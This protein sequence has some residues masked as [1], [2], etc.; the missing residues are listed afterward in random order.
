MSRRST[1]AS[2]NKNTQ[3]AT[4]AP[5][6]APVATASVETLGAAEAALELPTV[7][8]L[9]T[10]QRRYGNRAASLIQRQSSDGGELDSNIS[11]QI[12]RTRGG[13]SPL[14]IGLR[15][16]LEQSFG[17]NFSGVRVHTDQQADTLN[18]S[19]QAKAFTLGS[20]IYFRKGNYQ[21]GTSGGQELLAH[22]LTHVV[23]QGGARVSRVQTKLTVGPVGD[24]YE[25]EAD[26]VA[27]QVVSGLSRSHIQRAPL[28]RV[29][30]KAASTVQRKF[31]LNPLNWFKSDEQIKQ[32]QEKSEKKKAAKQGEIKASLEDGAAYERHLGKYIYNHATANTAAKTVN[33]KLVSALVPEF[34]AEDEAQQK[35]IGQT[36]G[37]TG[38]KYAG[39][40]GQEFADVWAVLQSGNLRERMTATYNAMFGGFKTVFL[41]LIKRSAWS[42]AE[43]RGFDARKLK[44]RKRQLSNPFKGGNWG[45]KKDTYGGA[46]DY[47]IYREPRN[48]LDRKNMGSM[49]SGLL[50]KKTRYEKPKGE[51]TITKRK[52]GELNEGRF[53]AGLSDREKK[54]MFSNKDRTADVSDERLSWEEGGSKWDMNDKSAWVQRIKND[55]KMPVIAGPSGTALRFFQMWEWLKKPIKSVEWRLALLG[56]MLVEND[57]SFHE[58]MQMGVDYGAPYKAGQEAYKSIDPLT[59]GELRHNV[60]VDPKYPGL[61]PD[62]IA[63]H[64]K[65]D[66][67]GFKLMAPYKEDMDERTSHA[68]LIKDQFGMKKGAYDKSGLPQLLKGVTAY[69]TIAYQI[70]NIVAGSS[71]LV[72]KARIAYMLSKN[73][74]RTTLLDLMAK[75]KIGIKLTDEENKQF[76]DEWDTMSFADR[77]ICLVLDY[78]P[79]VTASELI[80]ESKEHNKQTA[81][82]LKL[83]PKFQG[84]VYRG[85]SNIGMP[86]KKGKQIKLSKFLST[87]RQTGY[88]TS[89][90]KAGRFLTPI[91]LVIESKTGRDVNAVTVNEDEDVRKGRKAANLD[92]VVLLPGTTLS[93]ESEPETDAR[94]PGIQAV[95]LTE[96]GEGKDENVLQQEITGPLIEGTDDE[97]AK[98]TVTGRLYTTTGDFNGGWMPADFS[99]S[100]PAGSVLEV[101]DDR[102]PD[103]VGDPITDWIQCKLGA[104]TVYVLAYDLSTSAKPQTTGGDVTPVVDDSE[105]VK[106]ENRRKFGHLKTG[107]YPI[108][109][110]AGRKLIVF[111]DETATEATP[112]EFSAEQ[113]ARL[114]IYPLGVENG[115]CRLE[116]SGKTYYVSISDVFD[117]SGAVLPEGPKESPKV[118]DEPPVDD[119]DLDSDTPITDLFTGDQLSTMMASNDDLQ[120]II[121]M[122][123]IE[124]GQLK[125]LTDEQI[126]QL[127]AHIKLKVEDL[128][129]QILALS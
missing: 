5:Q 73:R 114:V 79:E 40:V 51:D 26:R 34:K 45:R 12:N 56:W 35:I 95:K 125:T 89:Y 19:V 116:F 3:T 57:H 107:K 36:F 61:F 43:K 72:A 7:N 64:R 9:L 62:E 31:S 126:V 127:A 80:E 25:Q 29:Q 23:Q 128:K 68:Q 118:E 21:P 37:G 86:Y 119:K 15:G 122:G 18:R 84:T 1:P 123:T 59:T 2:Q 82:G 55:L 42:E 121:D 88:V 113:P 16:P 111:K 49:E 109:F 75:Q 6:R 110:P 60:C 67:G 105:R 102:Y 66:A 103:K 120:F 63:Y 41:D 44:I 106:E 22:E 100:I 108:K 8:G 28:A 65:L 52:V 53:K 4:A 115:R 13:G 11:D 90:A 46:D 27:K 117:S 77:N 48:P 54:F 69:T 85:E 87:S 81:Y 104:D 76:S 39:N 74:K 58:I 112:L 78:N 101:L 129:R 91:A 14:P 50:A 33:E 47:D 94:W 96:V 93:V 10:L 70:M 30:L 99:V 17:S 98:P 83:L 32:E 20:D 24:R 97:D 124:A 38:V 71:A 92:E